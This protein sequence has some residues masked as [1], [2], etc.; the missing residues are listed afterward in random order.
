MPAADGSYYIDLTGSHAENGVNDVG[1]ISQTIATQVGQQ[2]FL[3]FYFGANPQAPQFTYPNDGPVK[4]MDLL[5]NWS[6]TGTYALNT[7]GIA[8]TN[9]QWTFESTSFTATSNLTQIS[10]RSL[11]GIVAPS[12]F[13]P[14]LDGVSVTAVPEPATVW[15]MLSSLGLVPVFRSFRR[16]RPM[17]A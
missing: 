1:T 7:T 6:L 10:F 15:L 17:A 14:L 16:G 12:D 13:G 8:A 9:P 11:N 4:A 2:Y 5:L 3:S